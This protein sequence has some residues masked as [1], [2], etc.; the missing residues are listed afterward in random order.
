[1]ATIDDLEIV[2]DP[3]LVR[4]TVEVANLEPL[5][6]LRD[7]LQEVLNMGIDGVEPIAENILENPAARRDLVDYSMSYIPDA[8]DMS[9]TLTGDT[10][11]QI[12]DVDAVLSPTPI[13]PAALEVS[14]TWAASSDDLQEI[15]NRFAEIA[16]RNVWLSSERTTY[17]TYPDTQRF[18]RYASANACAFCQ[19]MAIRGAVYYSRESAGEREQ[20]HNNCRCLVIP[21]NVGVPSYYNDWL[22]RYKRA[23]EE[24]PD[25]PSANDVVNSM[26]RD[27]RRSR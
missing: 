12:S 26:R 18:R 5:D 3:G 10:L 20:Y 19:M 27:I 8:N 9:A 14:A 6:M 24:L 23:R 25:E 22:E 11:E 1:M 15:L 7:S 2:V 13:N 21:E 4:G 17:A 16:I